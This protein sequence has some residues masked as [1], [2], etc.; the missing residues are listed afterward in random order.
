MTV[1]TVADI[2]ESLTLVTGQYEVQETLD[3][4]G[5]EPPSD[6]RG[7][8]FVDTAHGS[9]TRIYWFPGHVPYVYKPVTRLV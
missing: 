7:S 2:P 9:Y 3:L 1:D 5:V 6:R 4:A 8:L